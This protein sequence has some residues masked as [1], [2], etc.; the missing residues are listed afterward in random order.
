MIYKRNLFYKYI[1]LRFISDPSHWFGLRTPF[2][3]RIGKRLSWLVCEPLDYQFC[4]V[5]FSSGSLARLSFSQ[6]IR[7]PTSGY[8]AQPNCQPFGTSLLDHLTTSNNSF[9]SSLVRTAA[10]CAASVLPFSS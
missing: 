6:D 3:C 2:H 5:I 9:A 4:A 1:G 8:F 7:N 10:F